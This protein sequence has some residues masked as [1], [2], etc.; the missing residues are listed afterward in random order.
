L[1]KIVR[2]SYLFII[3]NKNMKTILSILLLAFFIP[4]FSQHTR[5]NGYA[6][7]VFDDNINSYYDANNYYDGKIKGGFQWGVGLEHLL[8]ETTGLELLYLHQSTTAPTTYIQA[9]Q[10]GGV[11]HT[12][13]DV[14]LDW[15]ML[16]G[17]RYIK[18]PGSKVEGFGG[19]MA[20]AALL[21]FKNPDNGNSNSATKFAWGLRGG[22]N[23]WATPKIS[24]KLHAQLVSAVQG[25]GGTLYFGTGGGGAGVTG[26][27]SMLQF[28]L[29][30]G[31]SLAL[32]GT[33]TKH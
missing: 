17:N 12:D 32:G 30:G 23:L 21:D 33:S 10:L 31:I 9:G 27:S 11:K 5:L 8:H 25:A 14:N 29:G 2:N 28:G 6:N 20:G 7:Y 16:G 4:A 26:Y 18:S 13:F 1:K 15:I 24:I 3:K 22:A 19:L